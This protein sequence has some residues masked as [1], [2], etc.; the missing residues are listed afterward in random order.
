[1]R[2]ALLGLSVWLLKCSPTFC[3]VTQRSR[4][5]PHSRPDET[6][7]SRW[8]VG[9]RGRRQISQLRPEYL[10]HDANVAPGLDGNGERSLR[11]GE[12]KSEPMGAALNRS[13]S[14]LHVARCRCILGVIH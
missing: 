3:G 5:R 14:G 4:D 1:M 7:R 8:Q 10:D 13:D 11:K 2:A 12:G 9:S 6:H